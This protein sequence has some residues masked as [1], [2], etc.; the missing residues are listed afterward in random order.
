MWL[1]TTYSPDAC[2]RTQ[3]DA[4]RKLAA[5]NAGAAVYAF[6][7]D[8]RTPPL[9]CRRPLTLAELRKLKREFVRVTGNGF[10]RGKTTREV[11]KRLFVEYL[12]RY[13]E[14]R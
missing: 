8:G 9:R 2:A 13:G 10:A 11:V 7:D 3:A 14:R 12:A 1:C 4:V 5:A 6:G